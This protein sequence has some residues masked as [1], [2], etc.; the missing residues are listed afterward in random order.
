[1]LMFL[2]IPFILIAMMLILMCIDRW[3]AKKRTS[4]RIIN[5]KF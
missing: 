5:K 2:S 3:N 1:M 4:P